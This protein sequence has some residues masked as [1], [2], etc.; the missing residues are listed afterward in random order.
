MG[1]FLL[2]L[3]NFFIRQRSI[4]FFKSYIQSHITCQNPWEIQLFEEL[5]I[6]MKDERE[7]LQNLGKSINTRGISYPRNQGIFKNLSL[8]NEI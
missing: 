8:E 5:K 7:G 1:D 3:C 2:N 6:L 4:F